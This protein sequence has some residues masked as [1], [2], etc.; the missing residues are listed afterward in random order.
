MNPMQMIKSMMTN[1]TPK[2]IVMEM[3]GK[4]N[5]VF[6]NLMQLAEKGDIKGVEDFARNFCRERNVEFDN[7]FSKFVR[8][9]K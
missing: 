4:D 7:E 1:M 9:F 2:Q 3:V 5:P 8:N 6:S